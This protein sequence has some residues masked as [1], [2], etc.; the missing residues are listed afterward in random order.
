MRGRFA[1]LGPPLRHASPPDNRNRL[2][3]KARFV[4]CQMGIIGRPVARKLRDNV[5]GLYPSAAASSAVRATARPVTT[6]FRLLACMT[7]LH[8]IAQQHAE[9]GDIGDAAAF[10]VEA[11]VLLARTDAPILARRSV[12]PPPPLYPFAAD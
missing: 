10:T 12:R 7:G 1:R 6:I 11:L 9:P 5:N 3:D 8:A 4:R 2:T